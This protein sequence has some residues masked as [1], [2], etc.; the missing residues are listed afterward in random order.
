[1]CVPL[2]ATSLSLSV[3]PN[4]EE[5][6]GYLG[7]AGQDLHAEMVA[8]L[9]GAA[10]KCASFA[11]KGAFAVFE[12]GPGLE[13]VLVGADIARHVEGAKAVA[14]LAVTL[15]HESERV[16]R[17]ETALSAAEGMLVDAMASSMA[18]AAVEALHAEVA[19]W[20]RERGLQA[21]GRFSPGYGDMP[22]SVQP[23]LLDAL[24]AARRL[25]VSVTDAFMLAPA[26]SVTAV[27]GLF[28]PE[29]A[30]QARLFAQD[31]ETCTMAGACLLK[32]QGRTCHGGRSE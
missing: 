9:E 29:C 8:R 16:I 20:A 19:A 4:A 3:C 12:D 32:R 14:L 6:L 2:F 13:R 28:D 10:A 25:G 15:G 1:M 7:Y 5:A 31:C 11:P 17:R 18:E 30:P 26:K 23:A 24:D 21:G 22:L 27:V